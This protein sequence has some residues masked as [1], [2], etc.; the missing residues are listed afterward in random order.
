MNQ[1]IH[2]KLVKDTEKD[3]ANLGDTTDRAP[4]HTHCTTTS[5]NNVANKRISSD[6]SKMS[7]LC[8]IIAGA[9]NQTDTVRTRL[10]AYGF[11]FADA[12]IELSLS[13]D[14]NVLDYDVLLKTCKHL[15][16]SCRALVLMKKIRTEKIDLV[17]K[18]IDEVSNSLKYHEMNALARVLTASSAEVGAED[19]HKDVLPVSVSESSVET[20]TH[21]GKG[22]APLTSTETTSFISAPTIQTSHMV[23]S[24]RTTPKSTPKLT[25][26]RREQ[27]IAL[28]KKI[29][30]AKIRDI[31][32]GIP[33]CSEKTIQRELAALVLNGI[34][35]K[36]GDRRWTVYELV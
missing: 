12:A 27:V 26:D 7:D 1:N 21:D 17:N 30:K 18:F 8:F 19:T 3:R 20:T 33:G 5:E 31:A 13:N 24:S 22:N 10:E 14:D 28:L 25:S 35:H 11:T 6:M 16:S 15:S 32:K 29:G 36:S 4:L 34:A 23:T 9:L 2:S